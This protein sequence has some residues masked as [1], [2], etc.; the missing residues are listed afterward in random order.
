MEPPNFIQ[1]VTKP[2]P[3]TLTFLTPSPPKRHSVQP[4]LAPRLLPAA[5]RLGPQRVEELSLAFEH[6]A[7]GAE[8][9]LSAT[10]L[11]ILLNAIGM[12]CTPVEAAALET[13]ARLR[14]DFMLEDFLQI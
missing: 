8:G 2:R 9:S 7:G 5:V 12:P 14:G 6:F 3:I 4:P 13:E 1:E 10:G 11:R